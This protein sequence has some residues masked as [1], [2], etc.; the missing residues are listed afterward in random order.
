MS[1]RNDSKFLKRAGSSGEPGRFSFGHFSLS[2][3]RKVT[4]QEAKNKANPH[5]VSERIASIPNEK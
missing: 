4:R 2:T 5:T 3:Q 1:R